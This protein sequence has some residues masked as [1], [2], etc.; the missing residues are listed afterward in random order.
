[1]KK[2]VVI[3]PFPP[4]VHGMAKNLALFANDV[5]A[6]SEVV[7][8]DISPGSIVRGIG[9]HFTKLS[10]VL[11]G[12]G[13]LFILCLTNKVKSIYMPP[14][15]GFGAYYSLIFVLIA[16]LFCLPIFLHHR[17][18]AYLHK[19]TLGM[20]LITFFEGNNT[21]HIFLCERMKNKFETMYGEKK[22]QMI[23]SNA[24]YVNPIKDIT[25]TNN[26]IVLGHLSNL[27]FQKG[28]KQVIEVCEQLKAKNIQF[29]LE[30]GGPTENEE[31]DLYL[32]E[33]LNLLS[34]NINYHGLIKADQKDSFYQKLDIFLF[35]SM[36]KNEAQPNVVFE[37]NAAAVPVL[38]VDTGCIQGDID[39][40]NG[41]VFK[42][43]LEYVDDAVEFILQVSKS[44]V[45]LDELK[46]TTL[47]KINDASAKSK[48]AYITLLK[49][50]AK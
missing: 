28:L 44:R 13:K 6:Y 8:I 25:I 36:Y 24:Q 27:G 9:Y 1:M 20:R 23:V 47:N 14:D 2:V 11:L 37:A 45:F 43:Q 42:S 49:A 5:K 34:A 17:S 21:T 50:V 22:K 29:I 32:K 12:G 16:R 4:P 41:A 15:A 30:L 35:P 46:I 38:A 33:K 10:R 40:S 48:Q 18:F 26:I 19:K 39:C 7:N 3:G 31:T